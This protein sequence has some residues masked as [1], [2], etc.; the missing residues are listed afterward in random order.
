MSRL[1]CGCEL[2]HKLTCD[3]FLLLGTGELPIFLA[4]PSPH[5]RCVNEVLLAFLLGVVI[6]V[7]CM[8]FV[9]RTVLPYLAHR[10]WLR[11]QLATG[12]R[13]ARRRG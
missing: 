7:L 5:R 10:V 13:R 6:G 4:R 1:Q 12:T 8:G 9:D 3:V 11:A 2:L